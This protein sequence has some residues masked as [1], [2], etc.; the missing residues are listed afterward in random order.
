LHIG[1]GGE[2]PLK[3]YCSTY[4]LKSLFGPLCKHSTYKLQLLMAA[5]FKAG[6]LRYRYCW[7][8]LGKY[9]T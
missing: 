1:D 8:P 5:S 9:S 4:T 2:A 7:G 6:I 3:V